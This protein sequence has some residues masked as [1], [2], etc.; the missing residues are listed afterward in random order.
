MVVTL[1]VITKIRMINGAFSI[2]ISNERT[3]IGNLHVPSHSPH[4]TNTSFG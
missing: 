4:G 1:L 2:N 3:M